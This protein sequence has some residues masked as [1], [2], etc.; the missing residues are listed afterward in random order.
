[1]SLFPVD[2]PFYS[3]FGNR[4]TDIKSYMAVGVPPERILI[5][6]PS[7]KVKNAA[8]VEFKTNY[9]TMLKDN[10]VDYLFPPLNQIGS[11]KEA[12]K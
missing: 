6:D 12:E 7:G 3:G 9:D 11:D 2:K 10:I 1:M 5:I 8:H 4:N